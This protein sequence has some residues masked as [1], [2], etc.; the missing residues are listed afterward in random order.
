MN[1]SFYVWRRKDSFRNAIKKSQLQAPFLFFFLVFNFISPTYGQT[2]PL[3]SPCTALTAVRPADPSRKWTNNLLASDH[4]GFLHLSSAVIART[5]GRYQVEVC[6]SWTSPV[7]LSHVQSASP[8]PG[9]PN[10]VT[11]QHG[12]RRVTGC[13]SSISAGSR[14][15]STFSTFIFMQ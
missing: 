13:L 1:R 12:C 2:W 3:T 10:L 8:S 6:V 7:R 4:T 5:E 14:I 11:R 15:T 9:S